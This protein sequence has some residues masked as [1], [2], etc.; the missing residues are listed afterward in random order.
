M[1]FLPM[2]NIHKFFARK[3]HNVVGA[4]IEHYSREGQIVLDPFCGSGVTISESLKAGRKAIGIDLDP[5][6]TFITRMTSKPLN[7]QKFLDAYRQIEK[8]LMDKIE[9]LYLTQC[10]SCKQTIP[11][12]V[13][14]WDNGKLVEV[15]Y[16]CA[17]CSTGRVR[18]PISQ[19]DINHLAKIEKL[20]VPS[21]PTNKLYYETGLPFKEKQKYESVEDLFTKRNLIALAWLLEEIKKIDDSDIQDF[22]KFAFTSISQRGSH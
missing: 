8:T 7:T 14:I 9:A 12:I 3:P 19:F 21:H 6:A 20:K 2:Y 17:N 4:Y 16:E 11:A 22:M 13:F 18:K 10:R 15:G 1:R 5:M